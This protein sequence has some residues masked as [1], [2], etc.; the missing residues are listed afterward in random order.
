MALPSRP[1]ATVIR[2]LTLSQGP[3]AWSLHIGTLEVDIAPVFG[4]PRQIRIRLL[5]Q[6]VRLGLARAELEWTSTLSARLQ[7]AGLANSSLDTLRAVDI[8]GRDGLVRVGAYAAR[9]V[10]V[11]L[12]LTRTAEGELSGPISVRGIAHP[13]VLQQLGVRPELRELLPT[14]FDAPFELR[15]TVTWTATELRF[16]ELIA[17]WS[18]TSFAGQLA[19]FEQRA[20]GTLLVTTPT[21]RLDL[22]VIG[23]EALIEPAVGARETDIPLPGLEPDITHALGSDESS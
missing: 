21:H 12:H 17:H 19:W 3:E 14:D 15:S 22:S 6:P 5:D 23:D 11:K 4:G 13:R 18:D 2:D 8:S 7:L 20:E 9:D 1:G 16:S 10:S